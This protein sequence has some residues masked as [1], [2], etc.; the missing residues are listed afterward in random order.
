MGLPGLALLPELG[1]TVA[2]VK[3][4]EPLRDLLASDHR[5]TL[6]FFVLGLTDVSE[7]SVDRQELLYNA[8]LLAHF[9]QVSTQAGADL[10]TPA[11]LADVFDNFVLPSSLPL[12]SETFEHAGAQCLLL[13]GFFEGQMRARHSISWYATLGAGFFER[14]ALHQTSSKKSRLFAAIAR[15]FDGWRRRHRQLSRDLREQACLLHGSRP[16][17]RRAPAPGTI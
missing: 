15:G 13:T 16:I 2:L 5:R 4:M 6:E 3:G 7:P 11:S 14:A 8:S 12:D 10:P 1:T 9:A 17:W